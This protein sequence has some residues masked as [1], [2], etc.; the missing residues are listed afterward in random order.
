[1]NWTEV[2]VDGERV[3]YRRIGAVTARVA[4]QFEVE[5]WHDPHREWIAIQNW[6]S[7]DWFAIGFTA[8]LAE[9]G[10]GR[11]ATDWTPRCLHG[12]PIDAPCASCDSAHREAT[13]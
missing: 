4:T 9:R 13:A 6:N 2:E 10:A 12:K 7:R 8:A 5:R 11:S 1:M 3:R